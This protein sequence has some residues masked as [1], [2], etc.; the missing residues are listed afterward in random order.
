MALLSLKRMMEEFTQLR[1]CFSAVKYYIQRRKKMC[2]SEYEILPGL[3][4]EAVSEALRAL[5]ALD[6]IG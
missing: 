1:K 6:V 5:D 3:D 4:Y 2:S